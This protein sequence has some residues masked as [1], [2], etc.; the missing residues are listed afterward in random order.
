[1]HRFSELVDGCAIF[2]LDALEIANQRTIEALQTSGSTSLVK[3]L[4]MVQLQKTIFAVGMFSIF[5]ASLQ[6]RLNCSDGFAEA[7]KILEDAGELDLRQRFCGFAHAINVLKHGHG[8]SY[9]AIALKPEAMPFNIKLPGESFFFEGDLSG[10]STLIEVNDAFVQ[11][12]SRVSI[13][14]NAPRVRVPHLRTV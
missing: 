2:T 11:R 10:V 8:R 9:E 6:E 3:T 12:C 13:A 7:K 14:P 5:D 1:M 4:Q